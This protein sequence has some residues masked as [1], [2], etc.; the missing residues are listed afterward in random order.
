MIHHFKRDRISFSLSH[1]ALA[2]PLCAATFGLTFTAT[3]APV[4][5]RPT[6]S[7]VKP[8]P[9]AAPKPNGDYLLGPEDVLKITVSNHDDLNTSVTVRPDGK[10]TLLRAGDVVARGKSANTLAREIQG[11]LERTLNNARV[12]VLVEKPRPRQVR[13]IGAVKN[14][15]TFALQSNG[16]VLDLIAQAGGLTAK[17]NRVSSRVV[18][19]GNVIAF[20]LGRAVMEPGSAANVTLLP[21]DVVELDALDYSKQITV[22]GSV[23]TPGAY[24]LDEGLTVMGL[25]ARAGGP[26]ETAALRKAQVLRGGKPVLSDLSPAVQGQLS[27]DSPLA[28]FLFQPGD[29]LNIPEN[30]ERFSVQGQ[31]VKP[32]YFLLSENPND[33]GVL[34]ALAQAGGP[35]PDGDLEHV[36]ITRT[37]GAQSEAI[38]VNVALIRA[39]KAPDNI[40]LTADDVLFV[41]KKIEHQV[42]VIGP[43]AKPGSYSLTE[44]STLL[45]V[46]ADA[47]NPIAG[48]GLSRAY[49][50]RHGVQIPLNLR[51]AVVDRLVSPEIANFKLEDEDSLVIPDMRNQVQV[52]GQVTHPGVFDLDD[53]LT[54]MSLLSKAG[55]PADTAALNHAYVARQGQKIEFDLHGATTG[56]VDPAMASFRFAPGDQLVV[57]QNLLRYA[58]I[59]QVAK[60]A[61]Y[62]FPENP[63]QATILNAITEAGGP[64]EGAGGASLS[65]AG[66]LRTV[67]GQQQLIQVDIAQMLKTGKMTD[68]FQLKPDDVLYIPPKKTGGIKL[69]DVFT[70]LALLRG[71]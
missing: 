42:N 71:F 28:H 2:V 49:V 35:L 5:A 12:Q 54:I 19:G 9:V 26:L 7:R 38:A 15:G 63:S 67:N 57:P 51:P 46:L 43:V 36:T 44:T 41:P 64:L 30:T 13:I 31:V 14:T 40:V 58:V 8:K 61:Y 55:G 52:I 6:A 4:K 25:L 37:R 24:D 59:G 45:S 66:I 11:R 22:M 69:R 33:A 18:R 34:K 27:P 10:I 60:P 53:D 23:K 70:P 3:A 39:G 16:H 50:L 20:D 32:S 62:P 21:N 17:S 1:F 68:N 29:V 47:G 48:A 56:I 65:K